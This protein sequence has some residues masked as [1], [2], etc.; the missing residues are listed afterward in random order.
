MSNGP[1]QESPTTNIEAP[2]CLMVQNRRVHLQI[3][4]RQRVHLLLSSKHKFAEC[5]GEGFPFGFKDKLQL[6]RMLHNERNYGR[7]QNTLYLYFD[8][9]ICQEY[10]FLNLHLK[11]VFVMT[12]AVLN[13]EISFIRAVL[14]LCEHGHFSLNFESHESP[15]HYTHYCI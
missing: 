1:E 2:V 5:H 15:P 7:G 6:R 8:L 4:R 12:K 10:F 11:K 9:L 14:L 3:K 13:R